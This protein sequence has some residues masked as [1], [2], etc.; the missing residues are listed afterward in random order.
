MAVGTVVPPAAARLWVAK[1]AV[2]AAAP[3]ALPPPSAC[4]P[5]RTPPPAGSVHSGGCG[6]SHSISVD[7]RAAGTGGG[8]GAS[9]GG[10]RG[11]AAEDP[12]STLT[13]LMPFAYP[14]ILGTLETLVQ[15]CMKGISSMT[16]LSLDGDSQL[17]HPTYWTMVVMLCVF[18]IA[19]IWWLRKGLSHLAASRLLP[20]EYGTVTSTSILGGLIIYQERRFVGMLNLWMMALGICLILLGCALVGRRKTI[21]KQYDPGHQMLHKYLPQARDQLAL[22][23]VRCER[24]LGH[25]GGSAPSRRAKRR[26]NS[27]AKSAL[28][29]RATPARKCAAAR[30]SAAGTGEV[31]VTVGPVGSFSE[32]ATPVTEGTAAPIALRAVSP[33]VDRGFSAWAAPV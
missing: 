11:G 14:I 7:L 33:A 26:G 23:K 16:L 1:G 12:S 17:C 24:K 9:G 5:H 6:S 3:A 15:M 22:H 32:E 27:P 29:T 8:G 19:V 18:S 31:R 20:V 4:D 10:A 13:Q 25:L 30:H 21:K 28:C 2:L